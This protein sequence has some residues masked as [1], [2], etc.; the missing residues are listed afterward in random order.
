MAGETRRS[1][2]PL[3]WFP[4]FL[5][6]SHRGIRSKGRLLGSALLVEVVARP[7]RSSST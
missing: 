2:N 4:G 1:A 7:T 3:Q 6:V 5:I